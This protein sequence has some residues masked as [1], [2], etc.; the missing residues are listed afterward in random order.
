VVSGITSD[1]L[2]R[3]ELSCQ[4]VKLVGERHAFAL[5]NELAFA[6]HMHQFNAAQDRAPIN[7]NSDV[8]MSYSPDILLTKC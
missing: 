4:R 8:M 2:Y 1:F 7:S 3:T 5:Q 6:N